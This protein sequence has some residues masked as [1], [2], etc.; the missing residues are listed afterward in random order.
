MKIYKDVF[1][2]DELFSDAYDIQLVDNVMYEVDA[3]DI[4]ETFQYEKTVF[5]DK[6]AFV[7]YYRSY[8]KKVLKYLE[9]NDRKAEIDEFKA[10]ITKL[11]NAKLEKYGDLEFYYGTFCIKLIR[12]RIFLQ[13]IR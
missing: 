12:R 11:M 8:L 2:G 3:D 13:Y 5:K 10:N 7:D 9:E 1:S 4:C 6:S